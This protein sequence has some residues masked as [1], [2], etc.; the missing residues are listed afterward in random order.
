MAIGPKLTQC[1][2][3]EGHPLTLV[4]SGQIKA[5]VQ[6]LFDWT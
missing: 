1:F 3:E 4:E 5:Q 6:R 2:A